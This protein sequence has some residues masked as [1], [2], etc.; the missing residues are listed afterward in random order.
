MNKI[1][2]PVILQT[3]L[4]IYSKYFLTHRICISCIYISD[5]P[6]SSLFY[7]LKSVENLCDYTAPT[8]TG[9]REIPP[10]SS[11][12][13]PR[14]PTRHPHW[15]LF[16]HCSGPLG[17]AVPLGQPLCKH[18]CLEDFKLGSLLCLGRKMTCMYGTDEAALTQV[19]RQ[20]S[21]SKREATHCHL[22][23]FFGFLHKLLPFLLS[24]FARQVFYYTPKFI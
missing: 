2:I 24:L 17:S 16:R 3:I 14:L 9:F 22:P 11:F 4:N 20:G 10:T 8:S 1:T 21:T 13:A 19:P 15:L 23:L 18:L 6:F 7:I 12:K 5:W